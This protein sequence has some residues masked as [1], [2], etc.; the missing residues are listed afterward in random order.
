MAH[1]RSPCILLPRQY[2]RCTSP[3]TTSTLYRS[4][5]G[6]QA[7][8]RVRIYLPEDARRTGGDPLPRA[9]DSAGVDIALAPGEHGR[10]GGDVRVSRLRELRDG[11]ACSLP[12]GD[13]PHPRGAYLEDTRLPDGRNPD[14]AEGLETKWLSK[15]VGLLRSQEVDDGLYTHSHQGDED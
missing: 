2:N 9:T 7:R 6:R 11:R 14:K 13:A 3:A 12:W 8:C 5:G 4:A 1:D 15:V 10:R